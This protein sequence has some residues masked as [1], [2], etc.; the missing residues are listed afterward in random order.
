MVVRPVAFHPDF[1][2][3]GGDYTKTALEKQDYHFVS[4]VNGELTDTPEAKVSSLLEAAGVLFIDSHGHITA[5]AYATAAARNA[6][7]ANYVAAGWNDG[8]LELFPDE[9]TYLDGVEVTCYLIKI[10]LGGVENHVKPVCDANGT[11]TFVAT[12]STYGW[13][14]KFG[15]REVFGY[16][17]NVNSARSKHDSA[18]LWDYMTGV[19]NAGN[20]RAAGVAYAKGTPHAAN[21]PNKFRAPT[22][23]FNGKLWHYTSAG[24]K[25]TLCPVVA[26][27]FPKN[28]VW[29][30]CI[31]Y[32]RFDTAMDGHWDD[33]AI[34]A[35]G[36]TFSKVAWNEVGE[37]DTLYFTVA[38]GVVAGTDY[39]FTLLGG[40]LPAKGILLHL[41]GNQLPAGTDGMRPNTKT[42][43]ADDDFKWTLKGQASA[44]ERLGLLLENL[45]DAGEVAVRSA[46]E[47]QAEDRPRFKSMQAETITFEGTFIPASNDTKVAIFSDDGVDVYVNG[48][49]VHGGLDQPQHLPDLAQSFHLIWPAP[50]APPDPPPNWQGGVSYQIRVVYSNVLYEGGLDIDGATLFAFDGGGEVVD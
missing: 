27:R 14:A 30:G 25:T 42:G 28:G 26:D 6:A 40:R 19:K 20:S 36:L 46:A 4:R 41:D 18:L 31:G 48:V 29:S 49:K 1:P 13:R 8:V 32:I 16:D 12:C 38:P 15:G 34:Q 33:E 47:D 45:P 5:E 39:I 3:A 11:V 35:P 17:G 24:G 44:F 50:A 7:L 43:G 22:P 2:E 23:E 9:E 21:D 37:K 10:A